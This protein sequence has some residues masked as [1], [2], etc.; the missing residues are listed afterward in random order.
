MGQVITLK[1]NGVLREVEVEPYELLAD[2]LRDKLG[3]KGVK[4][5]C[6]RGECGLCTIIMN[7][8]AVK[9]CI[10]L[11]VEADGAEIETVEGLARNGRLS[12]VQDAYVKNA[13]L[14]CGFCTPGFI[15][16]SEY[17]VR[18]NANREI[19]PGEVRS[20]LSGTICRCTGYKQ[21]IDSVLEAHRRIKIVR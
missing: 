10:I 18:R 2:V 1:V 21:I 3:Y 16:A 4:K 8:E 12:P 5:G 20:A 14:Q 7:G 15:M 19:T 17:I 6:W 11:A 13:G 9:S